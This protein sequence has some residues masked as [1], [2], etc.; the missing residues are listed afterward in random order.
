MDLIHPEI[1]DLLTSCC[2]LP[3][4]TPTL[5]AVVNGDNRID[6]SWDDSALPTVVEYR[7][8][9]SRTQGG[10]YT[11]I[12]TLPDS[13]PGLPDGQGYS[14]ADTDV[15][16][17]ITYYYVVRSSDGATC[18]SDESG[19]A[20][21][22]AT[23]ACTLEPIFGGIVQATAPPLGI[24]TVD[25]AWVPGADECGGPL[26]YNVYRSTDPAFV[27]GPTNL[28][29]GGLTATVFSDFDQLIYGTTYHYVV[30]AVDTSNGS[31]DG[32]TV[33][34]SA[35][36]ADAGG[37]ACSTVS[38]CADNPFVDV[39]PELAT[40]CAG[41]GF[42]LTAVTAG[43]SGP[44]EY[45]WLRNGAPVPGATGP[46]YVPTELGIHDYNVEVKATSCGGAIFDGQDSSIQLVNAPFFAGAT[47]ATNSQTATCGL[48]IAWD[49]ASTV[50]AGPMRYFVYRDTTSPV[51]PNSSN[52]IAA[53]VTG[54][55]F[56]DSAN[57]VNRQDYHYLVR[58]QDAS[59]G[60]SDG[61]TVEVSAF[62][63]GPGSGPQAVLDEDFEDPASFAAWTVT[64]GP[65]IHTC[66]EWAQSSV[67]SKRP[68]GG[69]GSYA[70]ADNGCNPL[71]GRTSTTMTSP[72]V[73]VTLANMIGVTLEYDIW[74][75]HDGSE[76]GKVEVYDGSNW[77]T[78]W[79]DT[80][81]DVNGHR[82]IDVWAYA[83][84]NPAF[85]VRFDYQDATQDQFFSVD[86]V[87]VIALVDVSCDTAAAG[88][89]T[90]ADGRLG[91][92]P[93]IGSRASLA[94]DLLDLSWDAATCGST[95][96]DLI[97]GDLADVATTT[98][99]GSECGLPSSGSF[100]WNGVPAGSLFFMIVGTDGS[101][102]EGGWG[103]DHLGAE[104]GGWIS[105]GECGNSVKDASNSCP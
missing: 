35:S 76:T 28:I 25:L 84:G 29:A 47:S 18:T 82:S 19:E 2:D 54:S 95:E 9:R 8:L 53:G 32:N 62:P 1:V 50:C 89:A 56:T 101:G 55:G 78:V 102:I 86:N 39:Q 3:P 72:P 68:T 81:G 48:D 58:A 46:I 83:A 99:S 31:E 21:A 60:Q 91:S 64:T 16:G 51:N 27:P 30:R 103:T 4:N 66:G 12:A 105:S 34:I 17:D 97:Y 52:L 40:S 98:I 79:Q 74:Y 77:V 104:R 13:S 38:A 85:R 36:P 73:D 6:L 57:L 24:C 10:P 63:D 15:S 70:I 96:Y 11:Q 94:G 90:V 59:T 33:R 44:F 45:Q 67:A 100:S 26:I 14:W 65:G 20:S 88:P 22:T 23:G 41:T 80:G 71:L 61:N 5:G 87:Q 37:A 75:N 7:I 93:L 92:Q 42:T 49:P 43:G 69:S